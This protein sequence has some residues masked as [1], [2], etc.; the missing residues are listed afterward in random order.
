MGKNLVVLL[1]WGSLIIVGVISLIEEGV[2][3]IGQLE[4][5]R[6]PI[7]LRKYILLLIALS[8]GAISINGLH[9]L[10]RTVH[11]VLNALDYLAEVFLLFLV[12]LADEDEVL[13]L[14]VHERR[15][16]AI[17]GFYTQILKICL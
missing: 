12:L 2:F 6:V 3:V 7:Q 11:E 15:E 8:R 4:P 1:I 14:L 17:E 9:W 10:F 5:R 16:V 13:A